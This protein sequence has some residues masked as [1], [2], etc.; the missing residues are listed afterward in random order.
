[1]NKNLTV[2]AVIY[3]TKKKLLDSFINTIDRN[4]N[5]LLVDNSEIC[6]LNYLNSKKNITIYHS[7]KNNGNGDGINIALKKV[8]TP[9]AIYFDLDTFFEKNFLQKIEKYI[10]KIPNFSILIPNINNSSDSP[11]DFFEVY[12]SQ[13]AA[14]LFNV[15]EIV[16]IGMFDTN[17]FLY[18]EESD[19]FLRCQK[20]N[21]KIFVLPK[22]NI[23]H[24]GSSSIE[25]D[26]ID[27]A[28]IELRN[29]HYMWSYFYFFKKNYSYFFAIKKTYSF[30]FKDFIKLILFL[31]KKDRIN[32]CIRISR[33][34]G[35]L[36]SILLFKS[37]K[38][39]K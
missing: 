20:F 29:W 35:L 32:I 19:L 34:T 26:N 23:K 39:L 14:M 27:L 13:G 2:I 25:G 12:N 18:R 7:S 21:K 17:Y 5:I 1:M 16:K 38:R 11:K 8:N 15:S 37:S 10:F 9:Y 33:L 28:L 30:L 31:I 4:Y 36:S 6:N 22:I 3:N 24:N